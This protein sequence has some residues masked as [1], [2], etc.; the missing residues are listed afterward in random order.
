M[1]YRATA[2]FIAS[3]LALLTY[4]QV[5]ETPAQSQQSPDP[6]LTDRDRIQPGRILSFSDPSR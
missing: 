6:I 3:L 5:Y 1:R 4:M 2:L